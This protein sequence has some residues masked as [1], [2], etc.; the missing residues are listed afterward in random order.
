MPVVENPVVS[1]YLIEL[2][3]L[4]TVVAQA[5]VEGALDDI[6]FP[7]A[8]DQMNTLCVDIVHHLD[9]VEFRDLTEERARKAS[10]TAAA[11]VV[12]AVCEELQLP[13]EALERQLAADIRARISR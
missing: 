11:D 1:S 10:L 4:T 9:P 7:R 5:L 13:D 12:Q 6:S 3:Q 8:V 2:N